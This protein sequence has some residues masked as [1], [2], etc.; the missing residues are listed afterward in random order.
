[1]VPSK[2]FFNDVKTFISNPAKAKAIT[3]LLCGLDSKLGLS[4]KK[5]PSSVLNIVAEHL[6]NKRNFRFLSEEK[7]ASVRIVLS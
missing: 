4:F 1:M 5:D 2:D 7:Q 6:K 3:A